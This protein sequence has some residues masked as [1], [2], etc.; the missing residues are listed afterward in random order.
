[1]RE[2]QEEVG[3]DPRELVLA[4]ADGL[5]LDLDSHV[6]PA[7]QRKREGEHFHHDLRYLFRYSGQRELKYCP[8]ELK[9]FRWTPLAELAG[10]REFGLVVEK[11]REQC[12]E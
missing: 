2:A 10:S 3:I 8:V 11:I 4:N 5:P 12:R 7:N 1:L 6:I 9:D